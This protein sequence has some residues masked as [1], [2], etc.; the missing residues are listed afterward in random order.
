M[1]GTIESDKLL[2]SL[3]FKTYGKLSPYYTKS[4]SLIETP[5]S[6]YFAISTS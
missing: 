6:K 1:V 2:V 4:L 5:P 3:N